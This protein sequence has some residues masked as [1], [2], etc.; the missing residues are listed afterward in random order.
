MIAAKILGH[1]AFLDGYDA[2]AF[3]L[4][5]AERR[6]APVASFV[7]IDKN[8]VL[9]R[10]YIEKPDCII[11]LDDSLI[12]EE[13]KALDGLE[14][15]GIVIVNTSR[16][17]EEIEKQIRKKIPKNAKIYVVDATKIAIKHLGRPFV[18]T[19]IIG[20]FVKITGKI[21]KENTL[22]ALKEELKRKREFLKANEDAFMDCYASV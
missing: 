9:S 19:A 8:K 15:N 7:R 5:G 4:Y 17:K 21:S 10:G 14:E 1:A 12:V 13:I 20:A 11:I 3:S 2:Q 16:T 22:K 18:N 6:G